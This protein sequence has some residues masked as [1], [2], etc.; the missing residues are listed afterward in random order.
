[1][2]KQYLVLGAGVAMLAGL[3]IMEPALAGPGGK[4]AK[5]T[6]ETFWGKVALGILTI[7][8]LPLILNMV[9]RE[10]IAERRAHKD[11]RYMADMDPSFDWLRIKQR[12]TDCFH[13]VHAAWSKEDVAE[14]AEYMTDWYWQNQQLAFID[15][16]EREGL[17]NHCNVKRMG[18]VKP[19]LFVHRNDDGVAHEGSMLVLSMTAKM[20]DYLAE[21]A[22]GKVVEGSKRY[23]DV[24]T[25]WSFT[26]IDGK[27][28]VSEI[29]E[30]SYTLAYAKLGKT[31]PRIEDTVLGAS[32][33]A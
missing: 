30:D 23:K 6:F 20:Q 19:L 16:W 22:S 1:M 28:R 32:I 33:R 11:L 13:R 15:R 26:M 2:N 18:A 29:E 14:A 5:A 27:W 3:M 25:V 9:I 4:I 12:A 10:K 31:L 17:V 21:R 8:F 7:I 24:E